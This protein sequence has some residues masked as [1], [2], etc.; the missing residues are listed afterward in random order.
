M[1]VTMKALRNLKR[2][3]KAVLSQ[4]NV[5]ERKYY[6]ENPLGPEP[7]D[8][9]RFIAAF[10]EPKLTDFTDHSLKGW[11]VANTK[12]ILAHFEGRAAF[13]HRAGKFLGV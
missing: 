13:T 10:L 1:N 3:A 2:R 8:R 11:I 5:N 4:A 6:E 9:Q 7:Y 12:E